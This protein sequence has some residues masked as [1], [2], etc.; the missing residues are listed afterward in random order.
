MTPYLVGITG[1]SGSGKTTFI[2]SLLASMPEGSVALLSQ[3]NYYKSIDQQSQDD[4]NI[5]NFDIPSS[6]DLD[7]FYQ[8]VLKLRAGQDLQIK[9]Y[10]FNNADVEPR[11]FTIPSA[12]VVLLEGI[13]ALHNP[14]LNEIIDLKVFIDAEDHHRRNRR[15]Q[16]DA[17]ERGYDQ[18]DVLYRLSNH[19]QPA[20]EQYILPHRSNA[21]LVIPNN[22]GFDRGLELLSVFLQSKVSAVLA[23]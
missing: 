4:N 22:H 21:D 10:T 6:L 9:E 13:Y 2:H 23:K 15:I 16:R 14:A 7:K 20:F 11:I 17:V 8:D 1:G 12:P 3:D 18:D 5:E 19:H